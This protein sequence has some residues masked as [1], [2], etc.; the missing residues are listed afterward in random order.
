MSVDDPCTNLGELLIVPDNRQRCI[1][2]QEAL[3]NDWKVVLYLCKWLLM[4]IGNEPLMEQ[5]NSVC[6]HLLHNLVKV[7]GVWG[8]PNLPAWDASRCSQSTPP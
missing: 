4:R 1:A 8:R 6:L 3:S 7:W 5:S 2:I